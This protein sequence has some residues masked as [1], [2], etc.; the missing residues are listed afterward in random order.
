[1][2]NNSKL[3]SHAQLKTL[4]NFLTNVCSAAHPFTITQTHGFLCAVVT[5]PCALR[6][7]SYIPLICGSNK[8][9]DSL[10]KIYPLKQLVKATG[11]ILEITKDIKYKFKKGLPLVP[12]LWDN[13]TNKIVKYQ[14]A[15]LELVSEWCDGYL[16][17]VTLDPIWRKDPKANELL[18]P[19]ALLTNS[20]TLIGK[21][22]E[23]NKIITDDLPYKIQTKLTLPV[24]ISCLYNFWSEARKNPISRHNKLYE[25]ISTAET[26]DKTNLKPLTMQDQRL[27]DGEAC[28]CGSGIQFNECCGV[29]NRTLN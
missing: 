25:N 22:D 14:T 8:D 4:S 11:V 10:A 20:F 24:Y 1:M 12:L 26:R 9:W 17:A 23:E 5:A 28:P 13:K 19:F 6:L 2:I 18:L 16:K 3:P 7:N 27:L 21:P 29:P 15:T